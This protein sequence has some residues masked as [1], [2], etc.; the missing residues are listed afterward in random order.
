M[1]TWL[2]RTGA[3]KAAIC[4]ELALISHYMFC[5]SPRRAAERASG[6]TLDPKVPGSIPGPGGGKGWLNAKSLVDAGLNREH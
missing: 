1:S 5:P 2:S 3:I 4:E 6:L